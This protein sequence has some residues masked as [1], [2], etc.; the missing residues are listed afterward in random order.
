[1]KFSIL[2]FTFYL[3]LVDVEIPTA[4]LMPARPVYAPRKQKTNRKRKHSSANLPN[5]PE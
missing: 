3:R 4:M 2:D 1:M 5:M